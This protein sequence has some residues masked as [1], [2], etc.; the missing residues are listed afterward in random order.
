MHQIVFNNLYLS[1]K[2]NS[3]LEEFEEGK[4][5]P[6]TSIGRIAF[7][8]KETDILNFQLID[9]LGND[10]TDEFDNHYF[11]GIRTI[12]FVSKIPYS[13][14]NIFFKFKKITFLP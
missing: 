7:A 13:N 2:N 5:I 10:V 14:S 3:P 11:A 12:L 1:D 4:I 6:Y 8:I 9:S